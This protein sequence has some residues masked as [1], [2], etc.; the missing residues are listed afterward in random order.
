MI[1]RSAWALT[2]VDVIVELLA[3]FG[4]AVAEEAVD[5]DESIEP[6]A[7]FAGTSTVS[8][9]TA[10][11]P[12]GIEGL[13]HVTVPVPPIGGVLQLQPGA[14]VNAANVVPTGTCCVIEPIVASLGPAFVTVAPSVSGVPAATGSGASVATIDKSAWAFAIVDATALLLPETG[15]GDA[16][17][18]IT[19]LFS[20][21]PPA[22]GFTATV[23]VKIADV[24]GAIDGA[25][26]VIGPFPPIGGVE[27]IH[28]PEGTIETN[29]VAAGIICVKE[30]PL[31]ML[32][33]ALPTVIV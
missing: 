17:E 1:E 18:A 29:P 22:D 27:H 2:V 23:I 4:S 6:S 14:G 7:A 31:A 8:E 30:S 9:K 10:T 3:P 5:V 33:P 32:G 15:S 11:A 19:E 24:D 25:V 26:Q 20:T 21:L 28:P 12:A 16:D 13:V